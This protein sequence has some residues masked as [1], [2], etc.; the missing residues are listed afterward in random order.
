M[1]HPQDLQAYLE[2]ISRPNLPI[3][4][5]LKRNIFM[6]GMWLLGI[7][8]FIYGAADRGI[9]AFSSETTEVTSLS[10]CMIAL[11]A[12]FIWF[13]LG[14]AVHNPAPDRSDE[15]ITW[16]AIA[17]LDMPSPCIAE[18][19]YR[20]PFSH[21]CQIYHLLNLKHLEEIHR[22]SLGNLKVADVSHFK[23]TESGGCMRFKTV[24]DSPTNVLRMWR[25]PSVEV[26]LILHTPYQIELRVPAYNQKTIHVLFSVLPLR[27]NEHMLSVQ[28][29]SDLQ[30]PKELLKA[31]LII[32]A[33]L[34]LLEDLPYLSQLSGGKISR[35]RVPSEDAISSPAMQLFRRY[36]SLYG[37]HWEHVRS[38][39]AA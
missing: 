6:Y 2:K 39:P 13:V 36:V 30:W 38:L 33:S 21:R 27:E 11:V 14:M 35:K 24:L 4:D 37:N 23:K 7:P 32:A 20:L 26:D 31:I 9:A 5:F 17:N 25:D 19:R 22:F 15:P 1:L 12:L 3:A 34:T 16:P 8:A 10:H 29:F 18:Q 28:M